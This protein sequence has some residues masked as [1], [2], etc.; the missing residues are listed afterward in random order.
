MTL[1]TYSHTKFHS[2][3]YCSYL[4]Q[5]VVLNHCECR[6]RGVKGVKR[7]KLYWGI[8]KYL[9]PG[10]PSTHHWVKS[11][12]ICNF[13]RNFDAFLHVFLILLNFGWMVDLAMSIFEFLTKFLI[14]RHPWHPW[15]CIR[16][17]LKPLETDMSD[18][19]Y[20]GKGVRPIWGKAMIS[21]P[22]LGPFGDSEFW[23]FSLMK[24]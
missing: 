13:L 15:V 16:S 14:F 11:K 4:F 10:Q 2:R 24:I 20:C 5:T 18:S 19:S 12:T 22:L 6:P 1:A 23:K 7:S 3:R 21:S 8:Q 9:S 17:D